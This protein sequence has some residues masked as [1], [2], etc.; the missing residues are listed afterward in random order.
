M[1]V[2]ATTDPR[3]GPAEIGAHARRVENLGFDGMHVSETIHDPFL[4]ALT[5][6]HHILGLQI[7]RRDDGFRRLVCA[8]LGPGDDVVS[9]VGRIFE[10][11]ARG[12]FGM[13]H[14]C[15]RLVPLGH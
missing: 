8:G 1:R 7:R 13:L 2:Y 10:D 11:L 12:L 9:L 5:A 15:A 6:L 4:L 14:F 3:L